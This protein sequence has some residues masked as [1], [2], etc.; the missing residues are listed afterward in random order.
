[1]PDPDGAANFTALSYR[2][3]TVR[4]YTRQNNAKVYFVLSDIRKVLS[5]STPSYVARKIDERH[6]CRCNILNNG[7]KNKVICVSYDGLTQLFDTFNFSNE[8]ASFWCW[9]RGISRRYVA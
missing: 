2:S 8:L 3:H 7:V 4:I 5:L 1:M 6:K 9:C